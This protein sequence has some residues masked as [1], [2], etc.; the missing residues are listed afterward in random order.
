MRVILFL[1]VAMKVTLFLASLFIVIPSATWSSQLEIDRAAYHQRLQGFWLAECIGNWTGLVTEMDKV[2]DTGEHNT[3]PF[4]TRDDW[5]KPDLPNI[6]SDK[7]SRLSPVIGFVL[8]KKGE[9]WGSDDDTDIEYIYQ[10]LLLNNQTS[11]LSPQQIRDGWLTHIQS[12]EQNFLWVSNE[13]AYRLMEKGILPPATSDPANNPDFEMIDA[14]LTTEIFGL[15]A[16]GRPDVARK[17]AYLPIRTTA[18]DNAA[19]ISEFYVTMHA[20]AALHEGQQPLR[21]HLMWSADIARKQLPDDSYSAKMYDFVKSLREKGI[22]WEAARDA[23]HERYQVQHADGYDMSD[24]PGNGSFAAGINFAASLV[25]LFWGEG[26]LKKTIQIGALCGW[27]AD[28]PTATWA[29]LLGFLMGREKVERAFPGTE[30]SGLY[31]ISRTRRNFP[32]RTP[33]WPGDDSFR[34]MADRGLM[35]IDR[36]VTEELGGELDKHKGTWTIPIKN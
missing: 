7:P 35:V 18:R 28:N 3:L 36:V 14:Q 26:D 19:W 24:K 34:L 20:L 32:D 11:M 5:G 30:L 10:E 4:Y 25:S 16:P 13:Q 2:G 21:Q 6:W 12:E 15:F 31:Q 33:T 17:L 29:G 9:V 22:E 23:I 27:D 1:L 8:R